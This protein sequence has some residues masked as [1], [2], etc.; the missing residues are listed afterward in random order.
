MTSVT[1]AIPMS[2]EPPFD[3]PSI[4]RDG[5]YHLTPEALKNLILEASKSK[6]RQ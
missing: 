3:L 2:N 1:F 4:G 6:T 5:L